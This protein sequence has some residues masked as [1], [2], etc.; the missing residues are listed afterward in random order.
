MAILSAALCASPIFAQDAGMPPAKTTLIG[1]QRIGDLVVQ[2][3]V[4]PTWYV[5]H[6]VAVAVPSS[7]Q[8]L[9]PPPLRVA[10]QPQ[11]LAA[12]LSQGK[13]VVESN[14]G[15]GLTTES[16]E[17]RI[18]SN[19][20]K[21]KI[22]MLSGQMESNKLALVDAQAQLIVAAQEEKRQ[23]E[24]QVAAA[25]RRLESTKKQADRAAA[26]AASLQPTIQTPAQ[27]PLPVIQTPLVTPLPIPTFTLRRQ[28]RTIP[29]ALTRWSEDAGYK[30]LW[31]AQEEPA[32]FE[33]TYNKPF[34]DAVDDVVRDLRLAGRDLRMCEYT[35]KVVRIIPR[36]APCQLNPS[37]ETKPIQLGATE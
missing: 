7:A 3:T 33:G 21:Q 5:P 14:P 26:Y 23:A 17:K 37:T 27:T 15:I 9:A 10:T 30:L 16:A 24:E 22:D 25:Q 13:T 1:T 31:E 20:W 18:N 2:S 35:N 8:N 12:P 11:S 29:A 4:T 6:G 28:D 19:D 36:S 32:S 34:V